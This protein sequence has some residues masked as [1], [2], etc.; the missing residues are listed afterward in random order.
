[1]AEPINLNKARKLKERLKR[2]SQ[3]SEN[4]VKHGRTKEQKAVD[5]ARA[6]KAANHLDAHRTTKDD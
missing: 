3:A 4:V 6:C 1:M 2:R 5:L